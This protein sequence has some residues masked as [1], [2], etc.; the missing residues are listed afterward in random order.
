MQY[1]NHKI[2]ILVVW[3]F[4]NIIGITKAQENRTSCTIKSNCSTS[5]FKIDAF[6][7]RSE[8]RLCCNW[9]NFL[10]ENE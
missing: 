6:C 8:P 4:I 7:C 10:F 1:I 3:V 9:L 5:F 2:V